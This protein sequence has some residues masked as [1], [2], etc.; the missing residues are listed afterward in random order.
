M[1]AIHFET[2]KQ[3]IPLRRVLAH[4]GLLDALTPA[5]KPD[6]LRGQCP[7]CKAQRAFYAYPDNR[8]FCHAC[9]A[10]GSIIDF[11]AE[12]EGCSVREAAQQLTT[13][14]LPPKETRRRTPSWRADL[15]L[16]WDY[17]ESQAADSDYHAALGRIEARLQRAES[18]P[19]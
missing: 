6:E 7:F 4:Y 19:S 18:K 3:T 15:K 10:K 8:Y 5:A 12:R 14:F 17:L 2:L 9:K 16:L 1:A 13:W 11:V